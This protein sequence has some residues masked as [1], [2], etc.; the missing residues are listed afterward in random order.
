T[1]NPA[2][3]PN[4]PTQGTFSPFSQTGWGNYFNGSSG[5]YLRIPYTTNL[6]FASD[7]TIECW[8]YLASKISSFPAIINNYSTYTTNGGFSIFAAHNGGTAGKYNIAFNGS[9]PVINSTTNI[10]YNAWQHIAL[11]RSGSTLT[12]YVDGVANG[13]STQSATVTGTANNWWIGAAGDDL[14]NS[15]INGYISNLRVVKD[16]ALYTG[17]FTPSTAPL[18]TT[19]VWWVRVF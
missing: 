19:T 6:Q 4:A 1:R 10:N 3:G 17:G 15:Y 11:V 13:T 12:L 9:F 5:Q 16:Q 7:F 8:V 2:T 18:T 14:V